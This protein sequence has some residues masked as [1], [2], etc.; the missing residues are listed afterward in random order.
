MLINYNDEKFNHPQL[1]FQQSTLQVLL[2][3][4]FQVCCALSIQ[5]RVHPEEKKQ[6]INPSRES[7]MVM[8]CI[9]SA[10]GVA[11]LEGMALLE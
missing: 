2:E 4:A 11:L 10:Q 9:C 7:S 8:V 3:I 6:E 5:I 1:V